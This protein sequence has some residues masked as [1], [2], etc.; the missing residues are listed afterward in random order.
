MNAM[1]KIEIKTVLGEKQAVGYEGG[2]TR[3]EGRTKR[4]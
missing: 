1:K 2:D 3:L 4:K